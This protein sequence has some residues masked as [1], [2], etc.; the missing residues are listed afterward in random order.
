ML[1][2]TACCAHATPHGGR[3]FGASVN[4]VPFAV[5]VA[6]FRDCV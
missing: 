2:L 1:P 6:E 5:K 3:G 4:V